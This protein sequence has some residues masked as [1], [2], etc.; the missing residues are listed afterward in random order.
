MIQTS[1][2]IP[3]AV[4]KR[5]WAKAKRAQQVPEISGVKF[6]KPC[7]IWSAARDND[8]YGV[9]RAPPG[10]MGV[11]KGILKAHRFAF[12][13]H[14]GPF[15]RN[16]QIDHMCEVKACIEFEHLQMLGL[17]E[18]TMK[19]NTRVLERWNATKDE[20]VGELRPADDVEF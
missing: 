1:Q 8:D 11:P 3:Q 13:L 18:H 2:Q 20:I 16:V 9:F 5:F 12:W 6:V 14:H 7:L 4:I 19:T 10:T 15:P 17:I